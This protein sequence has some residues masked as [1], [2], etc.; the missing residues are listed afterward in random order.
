MP[1]LSIRKMHGGGAQGCSGHRWEESSGKK[2]SRPLSCHVK[3]ARQEG[4]HDGCQ[5][6]MK[7][8]TPPFDPC[9]FVARAPGVQALLLSNDMRFEAL[10]GDANHVSREMPVTKSDMHK[11]EMRKMECSHDIR[12]LRICLTWSWV[13]CH[14]KD[15]VLN[16]WNEACG[17]LTP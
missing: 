12:T 3:C 4:D 7:E 16:E 10:K 11:K 5:H 15:R 1:E 14:N 17:T 8:G 9:S 13:P 6:V 2:S